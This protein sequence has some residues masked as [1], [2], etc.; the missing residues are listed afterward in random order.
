MST[1]TP[2]S[3]TPPTP[4]APAVPGERP[5]PKRGPGPGPGGGVARGP[6]AWMG[7]LPTEKSLDFWG[8]SRRLLGTLRPERLLIALTVLMG[9]GSVTLSVLGPRMLGKATDLIFAGVIGKQVPATASKQ[10]IVANLR[11]QHKDRLA[12]MF[13]AMSIHPGHGI[14]FTRVG[15]VLLVVL[16][17]YIGASLLAL[18]QG[19]LTTTIVQRAVFRLRA[20]AQAKLAR[21]PLS[22]FDGQPRGEL[23]SRVTNDIDNLAQTLQQTL[24]QMLTS[25]LTI[26]GVLAMMFWISP[27]LAVIALITVPV[28]VFVATRIGKRA[29]PK[30]VAQWT[31]TGQLNGHIEEMYSGHALV[32]VFGQ[33]EEATRKFHEHNDKLFNSAFRAQFISGTIQPAMMFIGN[34]NY[35]FIAVVGALRVSS[36]ALSLGNV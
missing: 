32:K 36:G 31:T 15:N 1:R 19:R 7:G 6:A 10:Q 17:I 25:L 9:V 20:D 18:L 16:W 14:D 26:I 5:T 2:T 28:S 11:R 8:S 23:L 3:P 34:V 21:L 29:Q 27:L 12:D 13:N 4:P 33:R 35:V 22:Y 24:S 30:F